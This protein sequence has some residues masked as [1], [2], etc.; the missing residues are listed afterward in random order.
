MSTHPLSQATHETVAWHALPTGSHTELG[1]INEM[2]ASVNTL[3]TP[4]ILQIKGLGYR[5]ATANGIVAAGVYIFARFVRGMEF[6]DVFQAVTAIAV[7]VIP[8]GLPAIIT[9]TLAIGLGTVFLLQV[10]FA[11][12]PPF[13]HIFETEAVPLSVWPWILG[14]GLLFFFVIEAEKL[15]IRMTRGKTAAATLD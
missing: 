11:Y 8:E 7:S 15:V 3:E 13:Q 10:M 1:R 5:I 2:L 12:L 14:G 6:V 9:I 4:L